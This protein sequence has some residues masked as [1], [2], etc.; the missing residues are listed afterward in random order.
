V[1]S[2]ESGR[3]DV[4][5]L[6]VALAN[7]GRRVRDAVRASTSPTDHDV[8]RSEGGD[9][10]YGVDARAEVALSAAFETLGARWPGI[11]VVEGHDAALVVGDA[12][13]PWVYL[14]DP[15][16]GTRP[17]LA[18][19]RSAWVLLGAG[20]RATTLE[21]LEVGAMV[22]IPGRRAALGLVTWAAV[23]GPAH[24]EEDDLIGDAPPAPVLLQP[25]VGHTVERTFVT[26]VRLLPGSHASIGAWA[27]AHLQGLDV[28]DDLVP[29]TGGYFVG[30]ATGADT[31]VFDP[32]PLFDDSGL[33]A[34]PYDLAGL[35]VARAAGAV[36][37]AFPSG[38]LAVPIDT[39]TPVAWA[40]YANKEVAL[41]LRPVEHEH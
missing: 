35:V 3:S 15:V 37:E 26:V 31:A 12:T 10:V 28:Y 13:G 21:D 1:T 11:A 18:G 41:R 19:K 14:V 27:D 39:S 22:E 5:D 6:A 7:V 24:G 36:I 20:R 8:I 16:D 34:H 2:D 32:R 9:D 33:A 38:S 17:Y 23:G 29:C 25:R 30:L 4:D 40:G